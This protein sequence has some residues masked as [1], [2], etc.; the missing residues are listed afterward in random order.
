MKTVCV[1]GQRFAKREQARQAVMDWIAF[2]N[3]SRL[4]SALGFLSSMQFEQRWLAAQ[5]KS[6]A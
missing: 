2:Y 5:R 6:A 3:H 1:H 4:H